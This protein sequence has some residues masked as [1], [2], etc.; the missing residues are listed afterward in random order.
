M[1]E[2]GFKRFCQMGMMLFES[3]GDVQNPF[4]AHAYERLDHCMVTVPSE[5]CRQDQV[6]T[7]QQLL[8]VLS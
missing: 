4:H 7:Q 1:V 5:E 8:P 3:L 2:D 6:G